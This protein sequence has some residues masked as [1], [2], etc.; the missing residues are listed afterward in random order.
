MSYASLYK[1]PK[2]G[3]LS[4]FR[5]FRNA[6]GG[7]YLIWTE[8][9]VKYLGLTG[10]PM[11]FGGGEDHPLKKLWSL[12]SDPKVDRTDRI[13]LALT[14]DRVLIAKK[15]MLE[16]AQC[17]EEFNMKYPPHTKSV[18]HLPAFAAALRDLYA[19]PEAEAAAWLHT[20]CSGSIWY[21][22]TNP[23]DEESDEGRMFDLSKDQEVFKSWFLFDEPEIVGQAENKII[24]TSKEKFLNGF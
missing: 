14:F 12:A 1:V 19:D 6:W 24:Q 20:S 22:K 3:S 16:A 13:V 8:M 21:V 15:D 17:L 5:Q 9:C 4:T 10:V 2:E 7:A 18:N 23:D 11:S